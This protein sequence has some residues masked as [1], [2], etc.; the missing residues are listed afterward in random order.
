[1]NKS[2]P[3]KAAVDKRG[4]KMKDDSLTATITNT[5]MHSRFIQGLLQFSKK[6]LPR[7]LHEFLIYEKIRFMYFI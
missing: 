3:V 1:M 7:H 4:R 5:P 2:Q 6:K